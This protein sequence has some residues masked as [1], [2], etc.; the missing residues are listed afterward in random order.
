M[1]INYQKKYNLPIFQ[2]LKISETSVFKL[3]SLVKKVALVIID[4]LLIP[5]KL[6]QEA[7]FKLFR[8]KMTPKTFFVNVFFLTE[9]LL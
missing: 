9:N 5:F 8:A 2:N 1:K 4:L 7:Y 6:A 3:A